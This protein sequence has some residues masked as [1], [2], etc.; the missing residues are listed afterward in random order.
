MDTKEL[1]AM[2]NRDLADEHAAVLRYL[3][4]SY[5]EGEDTPIGANLL[6]RSREEM[7]HMHWLGMIIGKL[8]GE[9]NL[10]PAEYPFDPSSRAAIL[11]SYI[12]YEENLIPHYSKEA[13][14]V[15]DPHIK[16][17]LR[18]EGWE[19]EV[20]ARKFQRLLKK[21]SSEQAESLPGEEPE[22]DI[23]LLDRLQAEV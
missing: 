11:E 2:L 4:H 15:T 6:S 17:V 3:V 16:R 21:M 7:W 22:M 14:R 18:R 1:I 13:D 10:V 5:L 20:H 12:R 9:P 23:A 8:G 19:S